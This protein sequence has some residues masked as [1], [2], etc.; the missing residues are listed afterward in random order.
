[1]LK[2]HLPVSIKF[3]LN[4]AKFNVVFQR[5]TMAVALAARGSIS[6]T[7]PFTKYARVARSLRK[8]VSVT[9]ASP[10]KLDKPERLWE[11]GSVTW[12]HG[13][14]PPAHLDGSLRT[15]HHLT[16]DTSRAD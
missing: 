10:L 4:T 2:S 11:T 5:S 1:M 14:E 15:F 13:A 8:S 3:I 9:R 7:R 12:F 16:S 6:E